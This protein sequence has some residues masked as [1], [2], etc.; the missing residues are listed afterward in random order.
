MVLSS[1]SHNYVVK[2]FR[3]LNCIWCFHLTSEHVHA[4]QQR[5][6]SSLQVGAWE[7]AAVEAM[8]T[9]ISRYVA[10]HSVRWNEPVAVYTNSVVTVLLCLAGM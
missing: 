9:F 2:L 8:I 4:H 10:L 6:A 3:Y 1:Q 5:C 7:G